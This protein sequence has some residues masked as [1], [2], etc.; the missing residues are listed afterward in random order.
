MH[1][2]YRICRKG[3]AIKIITSF[4]SAWGQ[5]NDPTHVRFFTPFT[6]NYFK[7]RNYSH[8]VGADKDMFEVEKVKLNFGVGTSRKLNWLFNPILNLN[9]R[10]YIA[11]F[12]LLFS[13]RQKFII[14]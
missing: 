6:F 2:L 11:G 1:E 7:K 3:S 10:I 4:Y 12:L 14:N 8:E 13:L 5:Y 9:H